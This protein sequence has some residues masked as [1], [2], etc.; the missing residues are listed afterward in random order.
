MQSTRHPIFL[1]NLRNERGFVVKAEKKVSD[2]IN[3]TGVK[4]SFWIAKTF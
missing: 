4:Y 3:E 1:Q 2:K